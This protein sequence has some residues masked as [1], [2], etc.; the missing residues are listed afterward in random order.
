M[1][2]SE[3]LKRE[4]LE[5]QLKKNCCKKAFLL[6][7][8]I[9][10]ICDEQKKF[11]V[12]N[13]IEDVTNVTQELLQKLYSIKT[14]KIFIIKPGKK[15]Y[16]LSFSCHSLLNFFEELNASPDATIQDVTEFK[17]KG[18]EQSFMRGAFLATAK[19]NDPAK[20]FNLEFSFD[21]KNISVASKFYRYLSLLG[22]V[23]K[24]TNRK[25]SIG[26]YIKN[27]GIISDVLYYIGAVKTSFDYSQMGIEKEIR[28][29]E[30][31]VTNC[32]TKNIYRAV[33]ASQK[34]IE[35]IQK[36]IDL[37]KFESLPEELRETALLRLN[38]PEI[39][40]VELGLMHS[41]PISKS[42][43]SHR[44]NKILAEAENAKK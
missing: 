34:H 10:S 40:M 41:P 33:N 26:F 44:L 15:Y 12:S 1:S 43:L 3:D 20:G 38:N 8:L 32:E 4:L 39:S 14:E 2:F 16:G 36:L 13:I 29:Y 28:N 9:N 31:R 17:C 21:P 37:Y 5:V 22:F 7:L 30:N 24:I 23:P 25:N 19:I 18:C 35:A 6:G 27:N 42:G 11:S